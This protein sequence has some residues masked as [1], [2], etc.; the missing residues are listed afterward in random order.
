ML[1]F[2]HSRK[3]LQ[4]PHIYQNWTVFRDFTA[5]N[6][7]LLLWYLDRYMV[8]YNIHCV[9]QLSYCIF[10]DYAKEFVSFKVG[11]VVNKNKFLRMMLLF[12]PSSSDGK[13]YVYICSLCMV[14]I[15][16][17]VVVILF[18]IGLINK[19]ENTNLFKLK[20]TLKSVSPNNIYIAMDNLV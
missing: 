5:R 7:E 11:V 4:M 15:G 2:Q 9:R 13:M 12:T 19:T 18:T 6:N 20:W 1:K 16:I 14:K 8:S 3:M 17:E 10:R